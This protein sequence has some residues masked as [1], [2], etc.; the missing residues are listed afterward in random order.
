MKLI[1]EHAGPVAITQRHV[2]HGDLT[3]TG[4][5]LTIQAFYQPFRVRPILTFAFIESRFRSPLEFTLSDEDGRYCEVV[6]PD[7]TRIFDSRHLIPFVPAPTARAVRQPAP[8]DRFGKRMH[9]RQ[10]GDLRN[11]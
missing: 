6:A 5:R 11:Q 1:F 4:R 7:G 9:P 3:H 8:V 2:C 10:F